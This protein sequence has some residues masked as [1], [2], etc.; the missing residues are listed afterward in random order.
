M[1]LV[2]LHKLANAGRATPKRPLRTSSSVSISTRSACP[3]ASGH[4]GSLARP[5]A[6]DPGQPTARTRTVQRSVSVVDGGV[7]DGVVCDTGACPPR[8]SLEAGVAVVAV[9]PEEVLRRL[10]AFCGV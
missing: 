4:N 5:G 3:S 10:V 2:K 8:R 6:S 7:G 9:L 1:A